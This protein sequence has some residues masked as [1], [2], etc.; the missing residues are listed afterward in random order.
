[1]AFTSRLYRNKVWLF[2]IISI[3]IAGVG[4]GIF[5]YVKT[6]SNTASDGSK[7]L[8]ADADHYKT[9]SKDLKGS[10]DAQSIEKVVAEF[11]PKYDQAIEELTKSNVKKWT[12][13]DVDKA[14]FSLLYAD[15]I[16]ASSQVVSL[17][18][19][20]FGA[21]QSGVNVDQNAANM[22]EQDRKKIFDKYQSGESTMPSSAKRGEYA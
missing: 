19:Q 17:Y 3:L 13:A 12:Q 22:T 2:A 9:L 21:K 4:T 5:F 6:Q 15:K 16:G 8:A 1:M 10:G 20:I 7:N 11:G 18:R 14:H